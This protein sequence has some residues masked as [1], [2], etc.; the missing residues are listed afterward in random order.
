MTETKPT[1]V[2][3][4]SPPARTDPPAEGRTMT[5][6]K[7]A[8]VVA[9]LVSS[10]IGLFFLFFPQFRPEKHSP[11]PEQSA[12]ITGIVPDP[13]R[14]R[15]D[16]LDYSDQSKT[17]FTK[18]QLAVIGASAFARVSLVGYKGKTLTFERQ[19]VDARTGHVIDQTRDFLVTPPAYR[20]EH[21]W[22]DWVPLR[23]G[24]G[25]YVMV[26]KVLDEHQTTAIACAETTP[27]GGLAGLAQA[28]PP[29][30]CERQ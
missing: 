17:G 7:K 22:W 26:M 30:V 10:I 29:H 6:A 15:G 9:G 14:T 18:A 13:R 27:F 3:K 1:P 12:R 20:V 28:T 23:S 11:P 24:R 21:R 25:A 4:P 5:M 8:G 19:V 16:Y 2:E